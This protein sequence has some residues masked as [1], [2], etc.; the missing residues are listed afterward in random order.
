MPDD[1]KDQ[2]Q[3]RELYTSDKS[4]VSTTD[5]VQ[6]LVNALVDNYQIARRDIPPRE[7]KTMLQGRDLVGRDLELYESWLAEAHSY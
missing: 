7:L 1:N 4:L 6:I 5:Q 2:V 3:E